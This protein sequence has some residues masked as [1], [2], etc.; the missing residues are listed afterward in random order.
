MSTES[1]GRGSGGAAAE[2]A[3]VGYALAVDDQKINLSVIRRQFALRGW[4]CFTA[5][6][7]RKAMEILM[8]HQEISVILMDF[9]LGPDSLDGEGLTRQ[10]RD[11]LSF[12]GII[13]S[14]SSG[15]DL[16]HPDRMESRIQAGMNGLLGKTWTWEK[17]ERAYQFSKGQ[18]T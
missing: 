18:L 10:I 17:F 14:C 5:E 7:S 16:E 11:E 2:K 12:Q 15:D 8:E 6:D 13:L 9:D 3:Y 1:V 4:K